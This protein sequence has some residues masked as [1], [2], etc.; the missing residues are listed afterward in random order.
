L[1]TDQQALLDAHDDVVSRS[2]NRHPL[3]FTFVALAAT[4][5]LCRVKRADG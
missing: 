5:A 2:L 4:V 3:V 1:P